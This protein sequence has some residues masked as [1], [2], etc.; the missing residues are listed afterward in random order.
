MKE[1]IYDREAAVEYAKVWA[2][3]R[4]PAFLDFERLGGDCTNFAS[5]CIYAG[6]KVMNPKPVYGWYYYDS[7]N[8]TASW[9]GVRYLY[10]F[11]IGNA[12]EGPY[13]LETDRMKAELG[14]LVQLGTAAGNF[15]HSPV[16]VRMTP[17]EV[18]VAAHSGD[19]WMRQLSSYSYAQSRFIHI[20]GIRG[21]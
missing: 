7:Y 4:N 21:L 17:D 16:I 3:K 13:A 5:Q 1:L 6:G 9:T 2:L 11:L 10:R 15:Y 14:D 18:F 20:E 8:R 19:A 12:G